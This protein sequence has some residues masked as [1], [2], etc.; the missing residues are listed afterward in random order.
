MSYEA[1]GLNEGISSGA[2]LSLRDVRWS[3]HFNPR[4]RCL[5]V[6]H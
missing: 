4:D 2:L 6:L 1:G 3:P 5:E